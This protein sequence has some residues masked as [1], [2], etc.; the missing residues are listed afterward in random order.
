MESTVNSV[1]FWA[2]RLP[3][4]LYLPIRGWYVSTPALYSLPAAFIVM[5]VSLFG[6]GGSGRAAALCAMGTF[7]LLIVATK[8]KTAY[9][10]YKLRRR[11]IMVFLLLFLFSL[12]GKQVYQHLA[13]TGALGEGGAK[14]FEQQTKQGSDVLSILVAGRGE[15]FAGLYCA[16]HK[17]II[18]YGPW[19]ID[20]NG[21][22]GDFLRKYGSVEDYESY[23]KFQMSPSSRLLVIP[24]HSCIVG[25]WTWYGIFGLL[26][27]LYLLRLY[28]KRALIR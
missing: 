19:A 8:M 28:W 6:S 11:M 22:G 14:K 15:F 17:P 20:W 23:L 25:F 13:E 24:S 27:W 12:I 10:F 16:I 9:D 5:V 1:L 3:H 18:G 21:L 2:G 26:L 7:V 4:W